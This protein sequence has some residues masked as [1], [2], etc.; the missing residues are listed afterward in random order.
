MATEVNVE[1]RSDFELYEKKDGGV[2]AIA[3]GH[4]GFVFSVSR[5]ANCMALHEVNES[6]EVVSLDAPDQTPSCVAVAHDRVKVA[7]GTNTGAVFQW[8]VMYP[9]SMESFRTEESESA[10]PVTC[11]AW[12][13]RGHVLAAASK[14]GVVHLW[15]MVV[16]ALLFPFACHEGNVV[17]VSWTASGRMLLTAGV[18]GALR[19]WSPRNVD[20]LGSV[21]ADDDKDDADEGK[22][23]SERSPALSSVKWHTKPLTC[24]DAMD[25]NSRVAVTG[26]EDGS[27]LLSV[28]KPEQGCG[29]FHAMQSHKRPV[30]AV[31]FS[32]LDCPKPLRAASGASDGSIHLFDLDRRLPMGSYT[33]KGGAVTKLEFTDSADVLFSCGNSTVRAWDA[34]VAPEEEPPIVFGGHNAKVN[35]FG[36]VNDGATLAAACDDGKLRLFDMRYPHGDAPKYVPESTAENEQIGALETALE[37][38][39]VK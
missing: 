16:G 26:S 28:L 39:S 12:H 2:D 14:S 30:S 31:R 5:K 29:V 38:A 19:A 15:D 4:S 22:K 36:I 6:A 1:P 20:F 33:H 21:T 11:L 17:G 13:P 27:V 3:V 34:R 25:D 7:Y 18:D 24:L 37:A 8:D 32:S 9:T 35:D 23:T 10:G